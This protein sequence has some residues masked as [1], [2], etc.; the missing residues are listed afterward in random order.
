MESHFVQAIFIKN[1][2]NMYNKSYYPTP[3]E[4]IEKMVAPYKENLKKLN[5]LEP[6]AGMGAILEYLQWNGATKT[7]LFACEID[8]HMKATVVGKGFK[9]IQ[10]DFLNYSGSMDFGLIIMNPPFENGEHH[11][12]KA[13]EIL[14]NGHI[15]CLLNEETIKNE[16]SIYRVH[17]ANI[18]DKH[19]SVEYIGP[20]FDTAARKTKV[21]VALVRLEKNTEGSKVFF[22]MKGSGT[23]EE[24]DLSS[25]ERGVEQRDYI[26]A[27]AN[28]YKRAIEST[29]EMYKSMQ[30]FNLFAST[31]CNEY[32]TPEL[33]SA[34]FETSRKFGFSDA[35]NEFALAFQKH[36]WDSI[37]QKTKVA[38]LM[39]NKVRE[40]FNKWRE[41]MGGIDLN[42][43]NI[44][45]LFDALIQQRKSIT[46]EC[47]VDAFD[48]ITGY[49]SRDN[50]WGEKVGWKTN[51]QYMVPDKFIIPYVVESGYGNGIR[52]SHNKSE[53]LDD[54]DRAFCLVSGKKF[55]VYGSTEEERK[56][57]IK[58]TREAIMNWCRDNT[59]P[60]E[61]EFFTFKCHLKGTVHFKVK[62]LKLL[63]EFNRRACEKK[64]FVLPDEELFK[65]K[66][67]RD[68]NVK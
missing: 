47:I 28:S 46:D 20:A 43:E 31:F 9:V 55:P 15:V 29:R 56:F 64:G 48:K 39:T 17:L 49:A 41:E 27:V 68:Q 44:I 34:F 7:K 38:G 40:K 26:S 37:F 16:N 22:D 53:F 58:T 14:R 11:L 8:E 61:S 35:H 3:K 54:I 52:Y 51:S 59:K 62:D 2:V 1:N 4:L 13:W 57:E 5:I 21:N 32:D 33:I 25:A 36:A 12:L 65:G 50:R 10:D 63:Q 45:L 30:M 18:I 42:E 19:G 67:R 66:S 23:V 60:E 24:I 6:S